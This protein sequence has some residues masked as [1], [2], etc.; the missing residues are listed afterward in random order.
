TRFRAKLP[1]RYG[2]RSTSQVLAIEPPSSAEQ[3]HAGQYFRPTPRRPFGRRRSC[4]RRHPP[5]F[6]FAAV[7]NTWGRGT[8]QFSTAP[9][10]EREMSNAYTSQTDSWSIKVNNIEAFSLGFPPVG[11]IRVG[12]SL[13]SPATRFLGDA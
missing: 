4:Y 3:L 1:F 12:I 5:L 9:C 2:G 10:K 8:H 13:Y 11:G 6:E 7:T